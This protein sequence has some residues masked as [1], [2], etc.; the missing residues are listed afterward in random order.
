MTVCRQDRETTK[1]HIIF[2]GSLRNGNEPSL[3]SVLYT[4]PCLLPNLYEILV[5]FRFGIISVVSDIKQA[6]LQI[7]ITP[8]LHRACKIS[9]H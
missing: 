1:T 8:K 3:T 2:N 4:G 9:F 6:F 5:C 7:K